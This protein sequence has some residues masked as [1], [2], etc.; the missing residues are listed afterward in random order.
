[1]CPEKCVLIGRKEAKGVFPGEA[2][3]VCTRLRFA[4]FR[5]KTVFAVFPFNGERDPGWFSV[6]R[7]VGKG[8]EC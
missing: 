5:T 1:M 7:N 8:K 6:S 4:C 3:R 2:S